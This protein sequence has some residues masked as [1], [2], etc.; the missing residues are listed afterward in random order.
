MSQGWE[1]I[2]GFVVLLSF[3]GWENVHATSEGVSSRVFLKDS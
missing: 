1:V 3:G 2:A